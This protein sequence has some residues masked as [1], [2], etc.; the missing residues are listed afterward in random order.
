M[1]RYLKELFDLR[2]SGIAEIIRFILHPTIQGLIYVPMFL[3]FNAVGNIS[4]LIPG[5]IGF[6]I[7]DNFDDIRHGLMWAH[8][9]AIKRYPC[10]WDIKFFD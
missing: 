8:W 6:A 10:L 3:V 1:K 4:A 5:K 7:W 9:D 2:E